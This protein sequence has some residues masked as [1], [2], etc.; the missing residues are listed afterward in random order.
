MCVSDMEECVRGYVEPFG[1]MEIVHRRPWGTVLRI[2]LADGVE[3]LPTAPR[4]HART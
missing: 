4:S 1:A 3:R 2:P